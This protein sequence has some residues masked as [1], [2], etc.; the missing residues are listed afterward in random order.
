MA[1]PLVDVAI[2]RFADRFAGSVAATLVTARAEGREIEAI[3]ISERELAAAA[4]DFARILKTLLPAGEEADL[5]E[6]IVSKSRS[7][8]AAQLALHRPS[9]RKQRPPFKR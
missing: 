6:L 9:L 8:L 4:R 1:E 2:A 7:A 3:A 5:I